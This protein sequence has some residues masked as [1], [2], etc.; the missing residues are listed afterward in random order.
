MHFTRLPTVLGLALCAAAQDMPQGILGFNSGATMTNN[1][2]KVE[3]DF[4]DEFTTAQRLRGSPDVFNSVRLY[5]MIQAGTRTDPITAFP[6]AIKTNTSILLGIWCSGTTTIENELAAMNNAIEQYGQ[7]WADLVV[8]ISVGSEDLYRSS[9]SGVEN[10]A[11][12]GQD[13]DTIVR[14]IRETRDA[15][16][17]TILANKPVIH[18]DAWSAWANSSNTDVIENSDAIGTDLY[19]Y[20]T[21]DLGNAFSNTTEVYD[22]IWN[23]TLRFANDTPVWVTETGHPHAGP[24]VGE[25]VASVD[26]SAQYWQIVGCD[27]LFGRVNTWWYNLRDSNTAIEEKFGI[28]EDLSTTARFNLTCPADSGAPA[29]VNLGPDSDSSAPGTGIP[30]LYTLGM[31]VMVFWV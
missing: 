9:E 4:E 14:F 16:A 29:A 15:I 28:T 31:A 18:V 1:R 27:R 12:P 13:P 10:D 21:Y 26:N 24:D 25:S 8:A 5:T 20:Y 30:W 3:S 23:Q 22:Y 19:P 17:D 11:G 6:A 2:P 7:E